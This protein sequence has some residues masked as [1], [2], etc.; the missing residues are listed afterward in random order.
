MCIFNNLFINIC[1]Y[2]IN[3]IILALQL[4]K[5]N[6]TNPIRLINYNSMVLNESLE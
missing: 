5:Q 6:E 2:G 3:D 4:N 1:K